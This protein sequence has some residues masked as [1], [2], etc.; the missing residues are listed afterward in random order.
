[1]KKI[2]NLAVVAIASMALLSCEQKDGPV[3]YAAPVMVWEANPDFSTMELS[4]TMDVNIRVKAEAGIGTFIVKVNSPVLSPVISALT[5]DN[6][7]DMDLIGDSSLIGALDGL[8]GGTLPAGEKLAGKTE[9]NFNLSSLVPMILALSPEKGS[10]HVF[11]LE[12]SDKIGQSFS[13]KLTF[14]YGGGNSISVSGADLWNNTASIMVS[15]A[16]SVKA[17]AVFFGKKGG[18][19]YELAADE[20]GK[21]VAAPSYETSVNAGGFD[22]LTVK[23]GTGIYASNVYVAELREGDQ[24]LAS[25]EFSAPEGDAI[26]NADIP[27]LGGCERQ[28]I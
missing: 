4:Q 28:A 9:V 10:D 14:H 20:D 26:P 11:T 6:S 21:Y 1:M 2:L 24:V 13:R 7:S 22:V 17:P 5:S 16:E 25:C 8:T 3:A 15:C 12:V 27:R 23:K 18:T 19:L